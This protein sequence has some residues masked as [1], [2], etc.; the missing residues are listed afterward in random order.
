MLT[1]KKYFNEL[2]RY[3]SRISMRV[4]NESFFIQSNSVV[5]RGSE[6]SHT[7]CMS[8]VHYS[9]TRGSTKILFILYTLIN[10]SHLLR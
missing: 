8:F 5:P 6:I 3:K 2:N 4:P 10:F 7:K 9:K 1:Q